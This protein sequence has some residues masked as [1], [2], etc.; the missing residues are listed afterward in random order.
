VRVQGQVLVPV[1]EQVW[2]LGLERHKQPGYLAKLSSILRLGYTLFSFL[3]FLSKLFYQ[4]IF[5]IFL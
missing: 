5:H 1:R 4:A 2:A 3:D